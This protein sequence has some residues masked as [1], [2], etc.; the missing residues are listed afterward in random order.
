MF[1]KSR[2][3]LQVKHTRVRIKKS[4][5]KRNTYLRRNKAIL[6]DIKKE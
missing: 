3:R 2:L 5:F 6:L 4:N 1:A